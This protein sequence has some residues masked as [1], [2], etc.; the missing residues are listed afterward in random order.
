MTKLIIQKIFLL[1]TPKVI[2]SFLIA[3][4]ALNTVISYIYNL[5]P[6]QYNGSSYILILVANIIFLGVLVPFL[7]ELIFRSWITSRSFKVWNLSF[8]TLFIVMIVD[9]VLHLFGFFGLQ[10]ILFIGYDLVSNE[11]L[12]TYLYGNLLIY[13]PVFIPI[14][15]ITLMVIKSRSKSNSNIIPPKIQLPIMIFVTTIFTLIHFPISKVIESPINIL[16]ILCLAIIFGFLHLKYN[17]KSAILAHILA[18]IGA[19]LSEKYPN[20]GTFDY[21]LVY[22]LQS[23]LFGLVLYLFYRELNIVI[24][25]KQRK[26]KIRA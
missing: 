4:I 11:V 26:D 24:A 10:T 15:L 25:S 23:I 20:L 2:M 13:L 16:I 6:I 21:V 22:G 17:L 8:F 18:N 9:Y 12:K 14:Y 7:E 5:L 3:V 19:G 1:I